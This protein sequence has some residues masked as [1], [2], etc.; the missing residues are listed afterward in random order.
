MLEAAK[1]V[2]LAKGDQAEADGQEEVDGTTMRNPTDG[3]RQTIA[4]AH[5]T[6]VGGEMMT[7]IMTMISLI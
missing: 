3:A 4:G 7:M 2:R 5:Q 6:I 1:A